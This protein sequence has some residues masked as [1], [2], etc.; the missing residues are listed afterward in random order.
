M[1]SDPPRW[2]ALGHESVPWDIHPGSGAPR[3]DRTA[4]GRPFRAAI[5]PRISGLSPAPS[6]HVAAEAED[7]V[8][9]LA[10]FDRE[11]GGE[12]APFAMVLLRSESAASSQIENLSAS[13]RKI[14]EAELGASGS[15]HAQMIV[16]NVQAM[17]SALDLAEHMDT[18]AILAMHRALLASSDPEIAGQWRDD[19]VWIGGRALFG[20]GSP[21]GADFVPPVPSRVP[22][23]MDDLLAFSIRRDLPVLV[24][25]AVAHAQFETIHPFLDGNGRTGRAFMHALLRTHGVTRQVSVPISGG[26][27][28]DTRAYVDALTAYRD[29]GI[30][31]IVSAVARA[32]LIG[33]ELG[34]TLV[35]D[36]REVRRS[37]DEGP[38]TGLRSD[39]RAR[40]LADGLLQHPVIDAAS[41]R[42]ILGMSA[43]EDRAINALVER[44][45]LREHT[46]HKSRNRTW[47]APDVLAA[48]DAYARGSGRRRP[49]WRDR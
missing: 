34:R 31:P 27:L 46:D 36:L 23:L 13:A 41:A 38:L 12:I 43:N 24:Q 30:D 29:G 49:G 17:T 11:L 48:L 2:P 33:V 5:P 28:T 32:S 40:E 37:W 14:A 4:L 3:A 8:R 18:G 42:R 16:A 26:L 6:P 22:A 9:A 39:S 7:A 10:T 19:Q 25:V 21:H 1:P 20:A 35:E 47:R 44:G 45:I 15:E